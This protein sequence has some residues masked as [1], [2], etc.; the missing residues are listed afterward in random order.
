MSEL[1]VKAYVEVYE[2][3]KGIR[4][5]TLPE[6]DRLVAMIF[7]DQPGSNLKNA[8]VAITGCF[9]RSSVVELAATTANVV[10]NITKGRPDATALWELFEST[11]HK[12]MKKLAES[13]ADSCEKELREELKR[14]GVPEELI[15]KLMDTTKKAAEAAFNADNNRE[16]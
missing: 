14:H 5:E 4:R 1:R 13:E 6:G 7:S 8:S 3:G 11:L 2:D 16:N 15:E 12:T 9:N 10:C